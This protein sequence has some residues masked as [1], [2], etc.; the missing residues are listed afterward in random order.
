MHDAI[1]P[2]TL[3]GQDAV[4]RAPAKPV[5]RG[6]NV[7]EL[8][9][10]MR[11]SMRAHDG[12]GIAAPQVGEGLRM[13]LIDRNL[14]PEGIREMLQ[15]DVFINPTL[16][17]KGF[18]REK[19]EEGCLSIPGVFGEVSRAFKVTLKAFDTEWKP[20]TITAEG[21]LARVFQHEVDHLNATLFVD[22]AERGSLHKL[23]DDETLRPWSIEEVEQR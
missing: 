2:V 15:S 21:L 20:M 23:T 11:K 18:K 7:T 16:K 1:L 6:Q 13:F 12:I 17:R 9:N 8:A 3:L 4:L 19:M 5:E 10:A 22:R 14:F